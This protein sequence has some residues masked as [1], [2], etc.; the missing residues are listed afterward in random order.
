MLPGLDLAGF[1]AEARI[2]TP[3]YRLQ[4][5][6][7]ELLR[8]TWREAHGSPGGKLEIACAPDV[9]ALFD[10]ELRAKLER[11]IGA[12][13]QVKPDASRRRR[14]GDAAAAGPWRD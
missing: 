6:L 10:T 8:R 12:V 4:T 3:K 7:A 1:L 2:E 5:V 14:N 9:A 11:Q 13:V